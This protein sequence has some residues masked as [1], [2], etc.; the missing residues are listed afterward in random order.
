VKA[1]LD[2]ALDAARRSPAAPVPVHLRNAPTRLMKDLG[3]GRDY[4]YAHDDPSHFIPQQYLPDEV[5]GERFYEPGEFGFEKRIAERMA[6]W[7]ARAARADEE[8][9]T[10]E[11]DAG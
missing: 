9:G 2:A 10:G 7:A 5:A 11:A 3:Y 6:W 1:A 4:Q 8:P